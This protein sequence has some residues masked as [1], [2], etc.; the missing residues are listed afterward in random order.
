[1]VKPLY[2]KGWRV[3]NFHL[4]LQNVYKIME[5][6]KMKKIISL[7]LCLV[8]GSFLLA[9]CSNSSE[10]FEEKSYTPDTQISEINL[11]VRDRE[12]EVALSSDEQVYIQYSENSKEY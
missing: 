2:Q 1:M 9:G 12:I 6:L 3:F 10:P 7:A 11:D 5:E 4:T 8:L